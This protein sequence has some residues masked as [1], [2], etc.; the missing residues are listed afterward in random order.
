MYNIL[1]NYVLVLHMT[2]Q[3]FFHYSSLS[4]RISYSILVKQNSNCL[5]GSLKLLD[6]LP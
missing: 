2:Q 3:I 4:A 6:T 5:N 1:Y